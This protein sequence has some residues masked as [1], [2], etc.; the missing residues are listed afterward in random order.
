MIYLAEIDAYDPALPGVRTLR[1]SS[2][3]GYTAVVAPLAEGAGSTGQSLDP[4]ISYTRASAASRITEAGVLEVVG[5]NLVPWSNDF[6]QGWTRETSNG[7]TPP[8]VTPNYAAGPVEGMAASRVVLTLPGDTHWSLV[9]N[10]GLALSSAHYTASIWLKANGDAQVGKLVNVGLWNG[11][12]MTVMGRFALTSSW[13]RVSAPSSGPYQ[14]TGS[15]TNEF[16]IGKH[17][18][19]NASADGS[20]GLTNAEAATDFLIAGAQLELGGVANAYSPTTGAASSQPRFDHAVTATVTNL[21]LHSVGLSNWGGAQG[22]R[23]LNAATAPDGNHTASRFVAI[24]TSNTSPGINSGTAVTSGLPYTFSVH[25][26]RES[27]SSWVRLRFEAGGSIRSA[28]FNAETGALG[29]VDAPSGNITALA[30]LTPVNLGDGWWRVGATVTFTASSVNFSAAPAVANASATMVLGDTWLMWGAQMEQSSSAGAFVGTTT[31]PVTVNTVEPRGL[32]TEEGRTNLYR[33]S[34][35]LLGSTWYPSTTAGHRV[36]TTSERAPDG[37]GYFSEITFVSGDWRHDTQTF[38]AGGTYTGS[39]FAKRGNQPYAGFELHFTGG[40][41]V[42]RAIRYNFDTGALSLSADCVGS[43]TKLANGV[44]RL[45]LTVKDDGDGVRGYMLIH[46]SNGGLIAAGGTAL[47]WGAQ[48]EFGT[49]GVTSYIPSSPSFTSRSSTGTYFDQAG[50]LRTAA[51]NVARFSHH[52]TGSEW[53]NPGMLVEGAETNRVSFSSDLILA[54]G[55]NRNLLVRPNSAIAP[56]GTA[57]ATTLI[58]GDAAGFRNIG[59]PCTIANDTSNYTFS[60]FIKKTVGATNFPNMRLTFGGGT[61]AYNAVMDVNTNTGVVVKGAVGDAPM[62]MG[63]DD[64]GDWWRPWVR[65]ANNASGHTQVTCAVFPSLTSN[66]GVSETSSLTGSVVVWGA[67]VEANGLTSH[68]PTPVTWTGRTSIGTYFDS[69]GV[70]QTAASGVARSAHHVLIGTTWTPAGLLVENAATNTILNSADLANATWS[71][72]GGDTISSNNMSSPS[73]AGDGDTIVEST[74]GGPHGVSALSQSVTAGTRYTISAFARQVGGTAQRYVSL[75]FMT[76]GF[77]GYPAV[78]F[79]LGTGTAT[80]LHATVRIEDY[81]IEPVGGFWFR[82]WATA[83]ASATTSLNWEIRITNSTS[84]RYANFTG[85]GVSGM[86]LWG[87]QLEE[88][89]L[90]SYIPTGASAVTRVADTVT[91]ATVTRAVDTVTHTNP[92]RAADN[93]FVTIP[94]TAYRWNLLLRSQEFDNASWTK[95][96]ATVSANAVAAPDTTTTADKLLEAATTAE[97]FLRQT[98]IPVTASTTYTWSVHLKAAE[99][100]TARLLFPTTGSATGFVGGLFDLDAGT[101]SNVGAGIASIQSAGN[102]W[103]RCIATATTG[104]NMSVAEI[105][106]QIGANSYLGDGVSGIYAWGGMVETGSAATGYIPTT[107]AASSAGTES[108]W[109]NPS[110]G[111][112]IA[113]GSRPAIGAVTWPWLACLDN[114][115]HNRLGIFHDDYSSDRMQ[116]YVR[117]FNAAQAALNTGS[118]IAAGE[119]ARAAFGFKEDDFAVSSNG[120][121]PTLDTSGRLPSGVYRLQVGGGDNYWNGHVRRIALYTSRTGIDLTQ[122]SVVGAA[123]PGAALDIDLMNYGATTVAIADGTYRLLVAG[124]NTSEWRDVTVTG[125]NQ[126][127]HPPSGDL[128]V[129]SYAFYTESGDTG[130]TFYDPRIIEPGNFSRSVFSPGTTVGE[131]TV[132]AGEIVLANADGALDPL[133]D[134]GVDGRAVR[135]WTVPDES[136]AF[137]SAARW[138]TGTAQQVEVSWSRVTVR[139]RDRLELLR[140]PLQATTYA[141]TTIAGGMNEAEGQAEDLKGRVKPLLFGE[142]LNVPAI[143][144]NSFDLIYQVN[145]GPVQSIDAVYDAGVPLTFAADHASITALRNA[146]IQGGHFATCKA[147]GLFRLGA[148]PMGTVTCDAIEGANAAARTAAQIARRIITRSALTDADL[149]LATFTALDADNDAPV[150]VWLSD[151]TTPLE[152]ANSVLASIGGWL[153]PNRMG[154]FEA[155]RLEAPQAPVAA[156]WTED[157]TLDRGAGI[158]R[159]ATG[160]QGAGVPVWKVTVRYRRHYAV[161]A[162]N[163]VAGCV[164]SARRAELAQEWRTVTAENAAIKTKHLLAT[165]LMIDT[166]LTEEADATAEATRLLSLYSVRR[167]RLLV[168]IDTDLAAGID[169]GRTVTIRVQRWGYASGRMMTVLGLTESA[170]TGVTDVELWG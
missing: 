120:S 56:D 41:T 43:V 42:I 46:T 170:R 68:I 101:A 146:A 11:G 58:D 87:I 111:V 84:D 72:L 1:Y 69:A 6:T 26:K 168:P 77:S 89:G 140:R 63:C 53:V 62:A 169:L 123:L 159:I 118:P 5:Y 59:K 52:Y 99:R 98:S 129:Q 18:S 147:L 50:V 166:H 139:L 67:Q 61:V 133:L 22:S 36:R 13:Q 113:E 57:T 135:I 60:L 125:G 156:T 81:G 160:D 80:V 134:Y 155:G 2:G 154:V 32:L 9:R 130:E 33:N 75:L 103:F 65:A 153:L 161:Q 31:A 121:V 28:F 27:G 55:W 66:P 122:A 79:N 94:F 85:D 24:G 8:V 21:M 51:S 164:A 124:A 114:T 145:D 151:A 100:T 96:D 97:H 110:E 152:A 20:T 86:R 128:S 34:G 14:M 158:E 162:A 105:R 15:A 30:A 136:T 49:G 78:I 45:N 137:A 48:F 19:T 143:A 138:M 119:V 102:G 23:T 91:S 115:G 149:D 108:P 148:S 64:C 37:V 131:S 82:V 10:Y 44:V 25:Y 73:G 47:Y 95:S 104:S 35:F 70:M 38:T 83:T 165:E 7:T 16:F 54:S 39:L 167:D 92:T 109:F 17:R 132:G 107:S 127:I 144:A 126:T 150:G 106:I 163:E 90:S 116:G 142:G 40:T 93:A 88:G 3:S 71:K 74:L 141:G 157:E 117:V 12:Q 76:A 29:S 4:V 112:L